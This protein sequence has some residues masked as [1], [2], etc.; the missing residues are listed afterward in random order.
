MADPLAPHEIARRTFDVARRGY[1]QQEV[2]GFLHEVSALLE[3][4]TRSERELRERAERAEARLG[5]AD[6]P[7]ETR[8]L[9]VLGE[10]TTRVLTSAHEAAAE[11]R[12]KAEASAERIIA[13]ATTE[14]TGLRT[15]AAREVE[16]LLSD[17][18][19]E[20]ETLLEAAR[21]E[22]ARRS[23][24]AEE[25]V[26]RIRQEGEAQAQALREQGQADLAS[27][28][29]EGEAAVEAARQQGREM[30]AEA[31]AVRERVLRDLA[32]RRKRARQQVEKLNAGR[33]R[34][35]QAYDLVR[36]TID[37]ATGELGIALTD[38]RIAASAAARRIE[39]EPEPSLE[40][41]DAE[42]A[43]AGLVDLPPLG[44]VDHPH[45]VDD[46]DHDHDHDLGGSDHADDEDDSS[47]PLSGEVPAVET[48][49]RVVVISTSG[50][51]DDDNDSSRPAASAPAIPQ[52]ERRSRKGRR[53]KGFE[54]LPAGELTVVQPPSPDEGVRL[55]GDEPAAAQP[56]TGEE[57]ADADGSSG[58]DADSSAD[59][60]AGPMADDAVE[61]AAEAAPT[62]SPEAADIQA[63]DSSAQTD[64]AEPTQ[65]T[66]PGSADDAF[67]RLRA[68]T[69]SEAEAAAAE[70]DE[71]AQA[72]DAGAA[73]EAAA[74]EAPTDESDGAAE[75][76]AVESE[77]DG[78]AAPFVARS[79]AVAPVEKELSRRLKRALADEQNEV[80]DL[81]RR[82]KPK[83]VDDLLP[84]ADAHAARWADSVEDT[85][86]GA[87]QSAAESCGGKA[88]PVADLADELARG[89]TAPLRERIDRSFSAAD[90]NLDDVADRVRALYREWKGHRLA[91]TVQH[92]AAAAHARGVYDAI[93][94]GAKVRWVVDPSA[95]ACPDCDDNV[96]G[97][98]ITK[99]EAFPTGSTCAPAHPGC[100]CLVLPAPA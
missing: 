48:T 38:A 21:T 76:V 42:V 25:A 34:L 64:S 17:A 28:R 20:S 88:T 100:H 66:G 22:L 45:P 51:A 60:S 73:S 58:R 94:P 44:E 59:D 2:R 96:L 30:V 9:E 23:A 63:D 4:L 50:S 52:D 46:H 8:L 83:G 89:L 7:D 56:S 67:A 24:E 93:E 86:A 62:E 77:P 27:A 78:E 79:A 75:E 91:E 16:Q 26:E 40:E 39:E 61:L 1:E 87:A 57:L 74:A 99:G 84:A 19:A 35:L 47:G 3:R 10:E 54:G 12:S 85:L 43:A 81:L 15:T 72:A 97:G 71:A 5:T 41:L 69:G 95:G 55:I 92:F 98:A 68:A 33:E 14:A 49:P 70:G 82:A 13:E 37:E 65:E 18:K 36:R 80:L 6:V 53:R 32:A 90:G 31:Q 29:A 11:I